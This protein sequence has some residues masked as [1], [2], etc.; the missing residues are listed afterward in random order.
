[1]ELGEPIAQVG[2]LRPRTLRSSPEV[3]MEWELSLVGLCRT[4]DICAKTRSSRVARAWMVQTSHWRVGFTVCV[5]HNNMAKVQ[6][7]MWG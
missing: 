7:G 5:Q 4:L 6:R 3:G 1:M 2:N